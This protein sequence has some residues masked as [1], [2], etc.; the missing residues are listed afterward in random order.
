LLLLATCWTLLSA[1]TVTLGALI[2]APLLAGALQSLLPG[3]TPGIS[4]REGGALVAGAMA[5]LATVALLLPASLGTPANVPNALSASLDRLPPHTVVFNES[6]LGGWLL[7]R[8]PRLE[9]VI[10]GRAEAFPESHF[11]RYVKTSQVR[12]GWEK[13]LQTT[14]SRYALVEEDSPLATALDERLHWRSLGRDAG[15]VLLA[16]PR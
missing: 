13:F 15:Y 12:P 1:R 10:D 16:A 11:K 2:T 14:G 7:W 8:H 3:N 5:C 9:P 6:T 4:R